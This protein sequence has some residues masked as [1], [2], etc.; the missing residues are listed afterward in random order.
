MRKKN[1]TSEFAP[2]RNR[3][4]LENFR[5]AIAHQSQIE[6]ERIFK[7]VSDLP[8]PRFWVTEHRAAAIIGKLLAGEDP[9]ESMNPEKKRMFQE[10][11][12]RFMKLRPLRQDA[13][14]LDLVA[15]IIYDAAPSSY[16]SWRRVRNII[17]EMK[18]GAKAT[19]RK[20]VAR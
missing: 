10:I 2:E 8:A 17:Y 9:T 3:F 5:S 15:E 4:L 13:T 7:K 20:E 1:S 14:I 18:N 12:S 6:C 19:I 16:I 11:F